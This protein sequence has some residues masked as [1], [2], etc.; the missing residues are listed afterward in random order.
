MTKEST[1]EVVEGNT[2]KALQF[3][4]WVKSAAI[5]EDAEGGARAE[6]TI[7]GIARG[8]VRLVG[9]GIHVATVSGERRMAGHVRAVTVAEGKDG[10]TKT[11]TA[12]VGGARELDQ[13]VGLQ[14]RLEKAQGELP[15]VAVDVEAEEGPAPFREP[16]AP[17]RPAPR[18]ASRRR[19]RG[20]EAAAG[21]DA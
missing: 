6:I 5:K 10:G 4:L 14:V 8:L 12:K 3:G 15:G 17:D 11:V 7:V 18:R 16:E 21:P 19:A 13:L 2:P 20:R 9:E 1:V